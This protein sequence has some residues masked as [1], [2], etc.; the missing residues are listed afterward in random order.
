MN[1]NSNTRSVLNVTIFRTILPAIAILVSAG[2]SLLAS[3]TDT[4]PY[5]S[6]QVYS[7]PNNGLLP[8][9]PSTGVIQATDGNFYGVTSESGPSNAGSIYR[10]TPAGT[11]TVLAN[12]SG[13]NGLSPYENLVQASDGNFYGTTYFGGQSNLG[14]VFKITAG[15]TLT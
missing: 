4:S 8:S 1:T 10:I 14:T 7:F 9:G 11:M 2:T 5:V 3:T 15:G 12:F 13:T 6:Q